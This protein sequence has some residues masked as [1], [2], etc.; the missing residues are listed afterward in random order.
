MDTTINAEAHD[1]QG[2]AG[3]PLLLTQDGLGGGRRADA[4]NNNALT[5]MALFRLPPAAQ[6]T[7]RRSSNAT[8][9]TTADDASTGNVGNVNEALTDTVGNAVDAFTGDDNDSEDALTGYFD[10]AIFGTQVTGASDD[11]NNDAP[12]NLTHGETVDG[13]N[14]GEERGDPGPIARREGG[15]VRARDI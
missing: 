8:D 6:G 12:S 2:A 11:G 15:T 4:A 3:T 1:S 9:H 7:A 14:K 13:G 5:A 10:D